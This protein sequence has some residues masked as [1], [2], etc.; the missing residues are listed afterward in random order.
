MNSGSSAFIG[1]GGQSADCAAVSSS[2]Q[3]SRLSFQATSPPVRRTTTTVFTSRPCPSMAAS[4]LAFSGILRPPRT[5]S[6]AVITQVDSQSSIRLAS[7]SGE[8][9]PKTTEC[10]APMRAQASMATAASGIIG[11]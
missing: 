6:S 1:S 7:A 5:P 11:M 2:Y 8:N 9:P 4:V 3:T 10:T